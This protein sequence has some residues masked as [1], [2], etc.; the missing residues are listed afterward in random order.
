MYPEHKLGALNMKEE[1][2]EQWLHER[3]TLLRCTYIA[4]LVNVSFLM[5]SKCLYS[6][7]LVQVYAFRRY[8]SILSALISHVPGIIVNTA[9]IVYLVECA[10]LCPA[11]FPRVHLVGH[12]ICSDGHIIFLRT[13]NM[14][15][16][17][18]LQAEKKARIRPEVQYSA[19]LKA[20]QRADEKKGTEDGVKGRNADYCIKNVN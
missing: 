5:V 16:W 20:V 13:D 10:F 2:E 19:V 3:A 7:C 17:T 15:E 18:T 4:C 9:L 14:A 6:R 12:V 8:Y 11:C 1:E